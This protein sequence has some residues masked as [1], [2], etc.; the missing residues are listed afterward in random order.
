[1][2]TDHHEIKFMALKEEQSFSP[3]YWDALMALREDIEEVI[4]VGDA[5]NRVDP[6]IGEHATFRESKLLKLKNSVLTSKGLR[7]QLEAMTWYACPGDVVFCSQ[8]DQVISL[9]ENYYEIESSPSQTTWGIDL[10]NQ[11]RAVG[12]F[13]GKPSA[14]WCF[15]LD[16][17]FA[18][19]LQP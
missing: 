7:S 17:D 15:S 1:M 2:K 8:N 18:L 6:S 12:E 9:L 5:C 13:I 14:F 3:G 11:L 10:S 16:A 4:L 19:L